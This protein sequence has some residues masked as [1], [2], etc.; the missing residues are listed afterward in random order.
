MTGGTDPTAAQSF[1]AYVLGTTGQATLK[2]YGFGPPP[3]G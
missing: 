3:T 2:T 1:V